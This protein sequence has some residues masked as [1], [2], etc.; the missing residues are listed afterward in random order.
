MEW[1]PIGRQ[2]GRHNSCSVMASS[3]MTPQYLSQSW[4]V[5][6]STLANLF[7]GDSAL[8]MQ[9]SSFSDRVQSMESVN[10]LGCEA[11]ATQWLAVGAGDARRDQCALD[12]LANSLGGDGPVLE[13]GMQS[14]AK[15]AG[16]R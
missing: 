6:Q 12:G 3:P 13:G 11:F 1:S 14:A 9:L 16:R 7:Q 15:R 2:R 4:K 10:G 5:I 8:G